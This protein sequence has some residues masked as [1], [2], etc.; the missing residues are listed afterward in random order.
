MQALSPNLIVSCAD[1]VCSVMIYLLKQL[2]KQLEAT[3]GKDGS[4]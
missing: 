2:F 4:V 1:F 3:V